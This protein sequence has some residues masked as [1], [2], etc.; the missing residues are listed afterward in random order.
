[1]DQSL[2]NNHYENFRNTLDL[3]KLIIQSELAIKQGHTIEQSAMFDAMERD[4][5]GQDSQS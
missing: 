4:L 1:M 5:F 3:I 2:D